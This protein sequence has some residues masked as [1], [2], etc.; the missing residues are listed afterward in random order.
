MV[1]RCTQP[2]S[3]FLNRLDPASR[4]RHAAEDHRLRGEA[5]EK[6]EVVAAM[7]VLD[8]YLVESQPV[9]LAGKPVIG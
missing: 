6:P 8:R 4:H 2:L 7:R 3:D 1:K 5:F 9:H